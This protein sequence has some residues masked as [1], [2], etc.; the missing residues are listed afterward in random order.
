[1]LAEKRCG[2][3]KTLR[4]LLDFGFNKTRSDG[5]QPRCRDCTRAIQ[6][7]RYVRNKEAH[8]AKVVKQRKERVAV[9]RSRVRAYLVEHPCVVCKTAAQLGWHQP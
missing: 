3:C 6:A 8:V 9:L 5:L 7:E 4:S 1:M 2:H